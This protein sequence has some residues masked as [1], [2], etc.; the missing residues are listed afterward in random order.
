MAAVVGAATAGEILT[1]CSVALTC[2]AHT[3]CLSVVFCVARE[4]M[5]VEH[6]VMLSSLAKRVHIVS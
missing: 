5:L 2:C 6:C 4:T 3:S 1:C